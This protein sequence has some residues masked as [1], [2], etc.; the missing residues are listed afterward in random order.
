MGDDE[1]DL[2]KQCNTIID[3]EEFLRN[4]L[5][6]PSTVSFESDE[7]QSL[8]QKSGS[9]SLSSNE[10]EGSVRS[11]KRVRPR[12]Y[13]LSFDKSTII[14]ATQEPL[15]PPEV[16]TPSSKSKKRNLESKPL[17]SNQGEK[18][19]RSDSQIVDHIMA[20][21]KRRQQLS[22]KFIALSATIPGLKKVS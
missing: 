6:Q 4:I 10:M 15:P 19:T 5:Q 16:A 13:I 8:V 2:A 20:E 14:P 22:Q 18:K 11:G 17:G 1:K 21:R 3:D 12:R 9:N 7:S